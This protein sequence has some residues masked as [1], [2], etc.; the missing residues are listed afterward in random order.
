MSK[1][2]EMLL[3]MRD[4]KSEDPFVHYGL[5]LE[6]KSLGRTDEALATFASMRE[7]FAGYVPQYLMAAQILTAQSRNDEARTVITAGIEAA[8]KAR[9]SHAAGELESAL[10]ALPN[11]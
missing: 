4:A 8:R 3:K 6:Y 2:L 1:R 10:A 11:P 7:K 9:D 5:A